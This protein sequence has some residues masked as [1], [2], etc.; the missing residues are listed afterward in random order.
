M[1][2][3]NVARKFTQGLVNGS[4]AGHSMVKTPAV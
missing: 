4:K 2:D 1:F 3:E